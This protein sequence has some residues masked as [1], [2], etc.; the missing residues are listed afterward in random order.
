M[1]LKSL[2]LAGFKSF[3]NPTTF[4]FRHGITA[5]VGPNGCGKSNVIDAIRWVLGETSAKQLRGGAMSDVIFA[6]TQDKTAKS[7]AS[8]ELTFEHTQ[9][10]QTG[11]R[12]EFN[13]YQELSV[14][15]QV[16][17]DGRSDYFINGTRCRRRDVVDVFL[18]TG[19]GARSYAV[20]EQ[21]MI[22]RIVESSPVQLREFIEEAAGVSRYQ[23]RRE[24]TQKKLEK[25]KDNLARLHDMQSE[26]LRQQKTLSKQAASAQRYEELAL[27]LA[28][29]EQQLA[30]QQ[31]YQ[32][33]QTHQQQKIA[34][35][36]SANEVSTLQADY[37]TLKAQQDKLTARINQEQWLKDD[38][39]S[40]HYQQ[41]LGYQQAEHKLSDAKSQLA[42]IEQQLFGLA[43]QRAQSLA[44]IERLNAEQAEQ[45]QALETL[46]PQLTELTDKRDN[47][48]RNEQPLQRAWHDA[49]N[50]L[51]RLQDKNRSLEQQQAINA[52]AQKRH[53]QSDD[54]WQRREQ[55]WQ[56]LWQQL[57]QSIAPS[58]S[59]SADV[60][61][62]NNVQN[63]SQMLGQQVTELN[64][65]LQQVERQREAVDERLSEIQPQAHSL[66][67]RL[68][69]QQ[70]KLSDNEKRHAL[71]AGEYDTLH[72]I[73]HPKST[74]QQSAKSKVTATD[75]VDS[76][77]THHQPIAIA[78]LREQIELSAKGQEY[79]P[80]LDNIL[81]LWLDS[82]VLVT[83]QQANQQANQIKQSSVNNATGISQR[84]D[85]LWQALEHDVADLLTYQTAQNTPASAKDKT[86]VETS[87]SLWLP[88]AQNDISD[89]K[90]VSE[91][92]DSLT[93]R[94]LP[95][96]Q[97][98]TQ[99]LL[100]LW[101]QCYI[102]TAQ[103]ETSQQH[104]ID[105]L[106]DVLKSL[107]S[108]AVLLTVDGWLISRHGT[109]NLSKFAGA[110]DEQNDS[111]SQFL[112]QRLQQ[113]TRLQALEDL[114][115]EFETKIQDQRKSIAKN[116]RDYDA[117][118]VSLEE[119]RAQVEQL[120]RD[121]HQYQ[122]QLTTERANAERLQADSQRLNADKATL[123]QEKQELAQEQQTL[124]QE[125]QHIE[126]EI[127]TLTPQIVEA[128]AT[129]QQLQAE[130][131]ELNRARQ[132]DDDAWQALQLRIQ[133]SEMRLE[134][135]VSS[136]ARATAQHDKS[137]QSE[138]SLKARHEQQQSKLPALQE[139]LQIAQTARD[140]QQTLLT[141]RETALN[142]LKQEYS[143]QQVELDTLQNTLQTQQSELARH[144]TELALSAA[145][146]E[147]AS[148]HTQSALDAY[149]CVSH[150]YKAQAEQPQQSMSV[151]KLL[152][153]F[154]AHDRR[155]RPDKIAELESER[156]KLEKQLSKIGAVNLAAVAELAEV[157]ERLEPLAQQT[158]DIAASMQ[159][160]TEA[161]ASIDE[162]TK[163]L[164][165]QTLDAVNNELANLFAKVFGGG[166]ASLTLN[167]D[168]M[169]ANTPKTEQWRAGLT[170]MAQPKGKRNSRLA[171]LS[172]GEKTLTALSLIFAIFKQHP[173]P[174]CVL[175]EVDAPLDDANVARFTSLIHE[176]A[177]DLQFIFISHNKLTMQIADELKGITMP[178]AG[179]STL[180]S[181][182]L[183]E[184]ARYVES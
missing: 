116:Q 11:I 152:A 138:Q 178:S 161:I 51:S 5:I 28:D 39:Q 110:Q 23:V 103:F 105:T 20:I 64:T 56:N 43:Q 88:T 95:V 177:D 44:D 58:A 74:Q 76:D 114:L 126:G 93:D 22:G 41:Q 115:D 98:I 130:R 1:R 70:S 102:Y 18:G 29:I 119:T 137:L 86:L 164:F 147:D 154:I 122:Q 65:Q 14:R 16:N 167:T 175:D 72:Q 156:N 17:K 113:R 128:R 146:L 91:L 153:D 169:P 136:L 75:N 8:V 108:S 170:L 160:L 57:Q 36:R 101:Q 155:V 62:T 40:A 120:T 144:A 159:T 139:A 112:T 182:S 60:S 174:F 27:T 163:T 46:R 181:V 83:N 123:E 150:K 111:N 37:D 157:N 151:S 79:A 168:E 50:N 34:H 140:E 94:V 158:A 179:I 129:T 9:D 180:V 104:E 99:P 118:L 54:K 183:D 89:H 149:Y 107:P 100:S 90:F 176:L 81:A 172:G 53:Q 73:L 148:A 142:V 82:H 165:M 42:T 30:I 124:E 6:G 38:A 4:T 26:L 25:T 15:R 69:A 35:E 32:A 66:Q 61:K 166:Q 48:K 45:N 96:S 145:R 173:A 109:I 117:L 24:E 67:Q 85:S 31:L 80:L 133:Q 134:H 59:D 162:T 21:G 47:Y 19:L 2:K 121:K 55:N 132:A 77:G 141:T 87:H 84:A 135:S 106:T 49:Q 71:L 52:Q 7:V 78:T 125:Q 184:A 10:E 143:Q 3:A 68:N 12:H 92:S 127:A 171:V 97:L 131:S 13:L 33:K 63:L